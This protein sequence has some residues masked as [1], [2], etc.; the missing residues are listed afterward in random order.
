MHSTF[1]LW[2]GGL[3][4]ESRRNT[5]RLSP[6]YLQCKPFA[7]RKGFLMETLRANGYPDKF[8][9]IHKRERPKATPCDSLEKKQVRITLSLKG[10]HLF[11]RIG[12]NHKCVLKRTRLYA[13]LNILHTTRGLNVNKQLT[14]MPDLKAV[15]IIYQFICSCGGTYRGWTDRCLGQRTRQRV[16]M[17]LARQMTHPSPKQK[18]STRN[19]ALSITNLLMTFGL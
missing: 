12:Q 10:D 7:E 16:R 1:R 15:H 13:E 8:P 14:T 11:K 4:M 9:E 6:K 2:T 5:S 3:Q 17:C 18:T 19:L